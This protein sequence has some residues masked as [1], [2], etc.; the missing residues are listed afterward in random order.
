[1]RD[2]LAFNAG[3]RFCVGAALARA[4]AVEGISVLLESV[5]S[6]SW[7]ALAEPPE[8]RGH[9]PRSHR[10][11]NVVLEPHRSEVVRR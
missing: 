8:F 3:P 9:M 4:E 6:M 2:H 7:D 5:R 1:M 10:P 11:L